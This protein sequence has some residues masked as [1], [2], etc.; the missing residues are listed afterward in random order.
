MELKI[1]Q[2]IKELRKLKNISIA[3][4]S[5]ASGVSTG[6]ISQI[7]RD[8]VGPSVT[9]LWKIAGALD[10][11][12][13]YF[14]DEASEDSGNAYVVRKGNHVK[15]LTSNEQ[16]QYV[17]LNKNKQDR[18]L[19]MVEVRIQV[20]GKSIADTENALLS[21]EGEECGYVLKGTLTVLLN[22]KEYVLEEGDS[23]SF[24]SN[25]P[26]RYVN[27]GDVECVSVWAMTP[28]FF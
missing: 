1:G 3:Q 26:H 13:A 18:V 8:I 11:G 21:H 10:T 25:I 6:L 5:A 2:K 19:D 23:I 20:G 16:S 15:M 9:N 27:N 4:L 17:L 14:F 24:N 12:I 22:D 7:E 28:K